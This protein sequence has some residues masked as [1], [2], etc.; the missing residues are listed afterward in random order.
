[1]CPVNSEPSGGEAAQDLQD[2]VA[3]KTFECPDERRQ[4]TEQIE[5]TAKVKI[6]KEKSPPL[7]QT[8]TN[9]PDSRSLRNS[10]WAYQSPVVAQRQ[11]PTVQNVSKNVDIHQVQQ[12][13]VPT[14]RVPR[15]LHKEKFVNQPTVTY[16]Q[17]HT[18]TNRPESRGSATCLVL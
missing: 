12:R 13:Q 11:V 18:E 5:D 15:V 14:V 10:S 7:D 9:S 6:T 16:R 3:E 4:V 2:D 1:M 17:V 8:N